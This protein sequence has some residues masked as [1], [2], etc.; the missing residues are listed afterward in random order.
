MAAVAVVLDLLPADPLLLVLSFLN[1]TDLNR[2]EKAEKKLS[3][4]EMFCEYFS[5]LG[6]YIEHYAEVRTAWEELKAFLEVQCP[7]MIASLKVGVTEQQLNT[8]EEKIGFKLPNDY[9]CSLRIHNGQRL[10]VPGL[11]G[12][13]ALS[14]HYR[15]E[16]LLDVD[17]A[18]G[19][20][21]QR[22]GLKHCFPL[23]FCIHTGL[24]QYM[25]LDDVEGR[26]RCEIFYHCA[27]RTWNIKIRILSS[28]N[29][30]QLL[31]FSHFPLLL[32]Q[33]IFFFSFQFCLSSLWL[34]SNLF[35]LLKC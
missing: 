31:S 23:T 8:T 17:T 22:R 34:T 6:R 10:V 21:Q 24:S 1:Y 33:D 26:H 25:A 4:K 20:F 7:R 18:A 15:S 14:S 30:R 9:R 13:M 5:D 3:W 19:G 11:M 16:D 32:A 12:S 35:L 29:R 2:E 28:P 27:V